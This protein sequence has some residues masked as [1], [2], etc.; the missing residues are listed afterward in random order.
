MNSQDQHDQHTAARAAG[1]AA[2]AAAGA[3][4]AFTAILLWILIGILELTG[5]VA[6]FS[7]SVG[8]GCAALFIPPLAIVLGA[9]WIF[10]LI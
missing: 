2:G 1:T 8:L 4:F 10:S 9:I 6:A 5:L 7:S 3:S